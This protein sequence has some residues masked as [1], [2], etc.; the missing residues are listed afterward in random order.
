MY[1]SRV[2]PVQRMR[3]NGSQS[4]NGSVGRRHSSNPATISTTCMSPTKASAVS[5]STS[6]SGLDAVASTL[7][8]RRSRNGVGG[9]LHT[10]INKDGDYQ[11]LRSKVEQERTRV[12]EARVD[13]ASK[14]D[15]MGEHHVRRKEYDN[16]MDAFTEALREKRSV[17]WNIG[18]CNVK[19]LP[20]S[21]NNGTNQNNDPNSD[22]ASSFSSSLLS[23]ISNGNGSGQGNATHDTSNGEGGYESQNNDNSS[24][25]EHVRVHDA[26]IDALVHT[27]RN[28]GNVH[29]LRGEQ[30]E[31]MRYFTEVTTLRAQKLSSEYETACQDADDASVETRSFLSGLG[32]GNSAFSAGTGHSTNSRTV[33]TDTA[34][35]SNHGTASGGTNVTANTNTTTTTGGD[36]NSAL[37]SEINEDV[38][39]LDDLFRSISFRQGAGNNGAIGTPK[40]SASAAEKRKSKSSSRRSKKHKRGRI[41][42]MTVDTSSDELFHRDSPD[43]NSSQPCTP[44]TPSN[45][46]SC[47]TSPISSSN[48]SGG[49]SGEDLFLSA[50]TMGQTESNASTLA[51]EKYRGAM[52]YYFHQDHS[53]FRQHQEKMNSFA[54]RIDLQLTNS[55]NS[56]SMD[57]S[58]TKADLVLALDI[59]KHVLQ[60]Y[61][62]IS[63]SSSGKKSN[64]MQTT[65]P[66]SSSSCSSSQK[67]QSMLSI[68]SSESSSSLSLSSS[69]SSTSFRRKSKRERRQELAAHIASVLICTGSVYYR[70][71]NRNEELEAY[72]KAKNVYCKAFGENHVFVAGTRKNI[73]MVL[74]ERG[75]YDLA[76]RQFEKAMSIYVQQNKARQQPRQN[77]DGELEVCW[78]NELQNANMNRDVASVISCIGNVKNR[79][80]ELDA[81]LT[82]YLQAL[83]IYRSL[84]ELKHE[85]NNMNK[86]RNPDVESLRDVTSTLKVIGMVHAKR[87]DLDTAMQFFQESMALLRRHEVETPIKS[88]SSALVVDDETATTATNDTVSEANRLVIRET[89]ASVLTRIASIH[90]KKGELD[91]AMASYREAYDL[92]VQNRGNTTNHPEIAGILHYIGG[93]FHKRGEYDEAMACYQESIRIYHSTLGSD[94][95]TV[96]GT[97]VM[98]GSIHYKRRHLDS[99]M[100]FYREALRLNRDAYGMHHPDVAPILKSI[101]TIL[102]K[103]GEYHEAYDLFRDVLSVKVTVHGTDHPE[104]ASAY[105]SLGN[106]HYKL[107]ELGDAE[108]Q[109]RHALSIY[110]RCRGD[111]HADTLSAKTT[112]EHLRYWMRERDQQQDQRR[113]QTSTRHPSGSGATDERSC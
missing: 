90:L 49:K 17:F 92:T 94:H 70:L 88:D 105:K 30:D 19:N 39:A 16:A 8:S 42:H 50:F 9:R 27:L 101:G 3:G 31:A 24:Y 61:R 110:R 14:L 103:K 34:S 44:G 47:P 38:R 81:A 46:H 43:P 104:V 74:A 96:A 52:D 22:Q 84:Y 98:V 37:M 97:L 62:E 80:G 85:D 5:R 48:H 20:R 63:E 83:Q 78:K 113:Q 55:K 36:E 57:V 71:G 99:A 33:I 67:Q 2:T 26:T 29:S 12:H 107:G 93:I 21:N 86:K 60:A 56:D 45:T 82:K 91:E 13:L 87:G 109:Y 4:S 69:T 111:D 106:V 1:A 59:Y 51:M 75:Q 40:S 11:V 100:M 108:R 10:N 15:E 79:V 35:T 68:C 58:E 18:N 32:G 53:K 28:I 41:A 73:G 112:I 25:L 6:L 66:L 23:G 76:Q 102:T 7:R 89:K 77:D 54:L 72:K 95:P 64:D 65:V